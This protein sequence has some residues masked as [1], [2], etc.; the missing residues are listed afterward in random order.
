MNWGT[1]TIG[2]KLMAIGA[3]STFV[4]LSC[5]LLGTTAANVLRI[6]DAQRQDLAT[7]AELLGRMTSPALAFDDPALAR[8]NLA[9]LDARSN[10]EAAAIYD[11]QGRRFATYAAT[12]LGAA[13]PDRPG[14]VGTRREGAGL[15]AIA[16]IRRDGRNLGWVFLRSDYGLGEVIGQ[17]LMIAALIGLV[18]LAIAFLLIGRL[19][20]LVT[21]PL[22]EV[23]RTAREVVRR[24]DYSRRVVSHSRDEVGELVDSFN[25]MLE[26]V[27]RGTEE[28]LHLNASLEARVAER[29]EA[30]E[31]SNRQLMG[32]QAAADEA[33]RAKSNFLATMSH[34]IRTPMNGVIGM[35]DVLHQTSL[36]GQQVEMVDLI[37]DSA[38]S[39]LSI[40]DDILD[41]SKIEAGRLDLER[42]PIG[43]ADVIEKSCGMM[44]HLALRK[45][46]DFTLFVDPE[47]PVRVL[48]DALRLRQVIVN[49]VNNAIK[50]SSGRRDRPG[51]ISLQALPSNGGL[52]IHVQDNGIG[53]D[54]ETQQRLFTAFSQSD[55]STTR[56]FG[57]TGLGLAISRHLVEAMGGRIELHSEPGQGSRFSVY[58]PVEALPGDAATPR[59]PSLVSLRFVVIASTSQMGAAAVAYL[60]A[61]GAEVDGACDLG[62]ALRHMAGREPGGWVWVVDAGDQGIEASELRARVSALERHQVSFLV[63][64]RG[65]RREPRALAGDLV[66]VDGNV[67][68]RRRLLRA[69]GMA[70]GRVVEAAAPMHAPAT[71]ARIVPAGEARRLGRM[72]LVAED[73]ETNQKVVVTQLG[74]LGLSADVA[75]NGRLALEAWRRGQYACVL[76]DLHMPEMDGYEL[77]A[78]IRA[79]EGGRTRTPILALT[80][81]ALEGEAERCRAVGMD[82]YLTKPVQLSDLEATLSAVLSAPSRDA[83]LAQGPV[84]HESPAIDVAVLERLVGNK[85]GVVHGFL[86]EFRRGAAATAAEIAVACT[87]RDPGRA[88]ASAH[89]LKASALTIGALALGRLCA[90]IEDAGKAADAEA[91][92]RLLPAFEIEYA[93]VSDHLAVLLDQGTDS[94]AGADG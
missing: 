17:S 22:A 81:N 77:T 66:E 30:L 25:D 94:L 45:H 64:G 83:G 87:D 5:A 4:A 84:A 29:T 72:V 43:L 39:L 35:V 8:E 60:R 89:S 20:K 54:K 62:E 9:L 48:G 13:I 27:Q 46:V 1:R 47:L 59:L 90:Q 11:V 65:P 49:L 76:T 6:D 80:A 19:G 41:F 16:P 56:R 78:A 12:G 7:Q 61:A 86:A 24:R 52:A 58:L 57:G 53:I 15:V 34:E 23:A 28:V 33:N 2:Q 51:R 14:A 55:S 21:R 36:T 38:F 75:A 32:L 88:T 44:D 92:M 26:E 93:A 70:A 40:I 71:K 69:A 31:R 91:L 79:S 73:N 63:L 3:L 82:D 50:F 67:L 18:S 10:I 74:L 37:K 68:T 42:S 85:P